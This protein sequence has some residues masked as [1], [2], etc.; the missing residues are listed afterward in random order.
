MEK[1]SKM[2]S[3]LG[4]CL[5]VAFVFWTILVCVVDVKAIGPNGSSVGFATLNGAVHSLTGVNMLLYT[6]T[7]WLGLVPIA[8]ALG[9]AIL[10]FIQLITRKSLL[11]VDRNII[12]LGIFYIAV[13]VAYIFFEIVVINHRPILING[14]LEPSYPSS[15]TMLVMC[16][17]P[18]AAIQL[19]KRIKNKPIR[20]SVII[21]IIAFVV[22]MVVGRSI[23]GVHWITDIIGGAL[24]SAGITTLYYAFSGFD[25]HI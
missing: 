17:M 12:T 16:V 15:T 19:N 5:I 10:G 21:V 2:I 20:Q 9:F 25:Q 7:D 18:T 1:K 22:F 11:R 4:I 6:I 14:Y 23:S 24:F 3:I 13:I 8:T